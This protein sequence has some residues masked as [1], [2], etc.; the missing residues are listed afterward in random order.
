M[1]IGGFMTRILVLMGCICLAACASLKTSSEYITRGNGYLQDGKKQ[2]AIAAYNKAVSLNPQNTEA[3]EARGAA[4]FYNG[5]YQLAQADFERVLKDNPYRFSVYTAYASVLAA[6]GN[7][8]DALQVLDLAVRLH[9]SAETYFA[10]GGVYYMLGKY[11]LAVADYT[12]TLQTRRS[13]DVLNARGAAY[14]KWGK[15]QQA[16]QDFEAAKS[17]EIPQ[18]INAYAFLN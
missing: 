3:Y 15:P 12:T 2:Q 6:Q 17:P 4:Y 5:Q 14:Q 13:A 1:R 8:K 10:R 11:D 16:Q 18:H 9:P 7:F